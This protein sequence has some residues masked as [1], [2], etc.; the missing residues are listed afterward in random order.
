M[1]CNAPNEAKE[2]RETSLLALLGLRLR[3]YVGA[4]AMQ[5]CM[6]APR[7]ARGDT[8]HAPV[9]RVPAKAPHRPGPGPAPQHV[10][11]T[12]RRGGR[13]GHAPACAG[14]PACRVAHLPVQPDRCSPASRPRSALH[15]LTHSYLG[16]LLQRGVEKLYSGS[17]VREKTSLPWLGMCTYLVREC[18]H[19]TGNSY[20]CRL[21]FVTSF[22]ITWIY[23]YEF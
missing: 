2:G 6:H 21:I 16:Q 4:A 13:H 14:T 12:A 23:I 17:Y 10:A 15:S 19:A 8:S 18:M 3:A 7:T 5:E 22:S 1:Q 11:P 20:S 9:A